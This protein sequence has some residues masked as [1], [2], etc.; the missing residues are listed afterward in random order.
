MPAT[1]TIAASEF[2]AKCLDILE[3]LGSRQLERVVITKRGR[4]VAVLTPPTSPAEAVQGLH[5]FLRG[6]VLGLEDV[7]L[8][9]PVLTEPLNADDGRLHE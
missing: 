5:G 4:P 7:D 9:A 6:A 3:R 1:Q 2:K 8:T